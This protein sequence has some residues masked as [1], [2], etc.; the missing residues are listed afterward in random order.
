[1]KWGRAL[2]IRNLAMA[3]WIGSFAFQAGRTMLMK[4]R[5]RKSPVERRR[6]TERQLQCTILVGRGLCE[7]AI[8]KRLG[9]ATET[10]KRHLKEARLS[11]G[12]TKSVQLVT[13][14]LRD[15]LITLRDIFS[16]KPSDGL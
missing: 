3:H 8:G 7:E 10:V 4:T 15:G 6:L 12:A 16:E 1:M 5:A 9:I 2:P 14:S 13:Q 11:Y